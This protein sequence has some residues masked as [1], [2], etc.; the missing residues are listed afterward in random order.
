MED[1]LKDKIR[2]S[3]V[4]DEVEH[5]ARSRGHLELREVRSVSRPIDPN[6]GQSE[7]LQGESELA[8]LGDVVSG[9]LQRIAIREQEV[10]SVREGIDGLE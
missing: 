9:E 3:V 4:D 6:D 1:V 5:E 10:C 8:V 7:V 2:R